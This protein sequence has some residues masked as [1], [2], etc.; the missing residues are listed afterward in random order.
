VLG[1]AWMLR[2]RRGSHR[3][4]HGLVLSELA[5]A[6]LKRLARYNLLVIDSCCDLKSMLNV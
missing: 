5:V 2:G 3:L 4:L 6:T 1:R